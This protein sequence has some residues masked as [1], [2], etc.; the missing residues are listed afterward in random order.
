MGVCAHGCPC[1][2]R[3]PCL[4]SPFSLGLRPSCVRCL[5]LVALGVACCVGFT[6]VPV[7]GSLLTAPSLSLSPLSSSSHFCSRDPSIAGD[8]GEHG[9][10]DT[11][12]CCHDRGCCLQ[13]APRATCVQVGKMLRLVWASR[14]GFTGRPHARA[15]YARQAFD[16]LRGAAGAGRRRGR[17]RGEAACVAGGGYRRA[18]AGA[19]AARAL[20]RRAPARLATSAHSRARGV[21]AQRQAAAPGAPE[22]ARRRAAAGV[23]RRVRGAQGRAPASRPNW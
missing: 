8:V 6:C 21:D 17:A 14:L 15:C 1:L 12:V 19:R 23:G 20:E 22:S 18:C 10:R 2:V 3:L 16:A 9:E 13:R 7:W 4:R 11:Q 5:L